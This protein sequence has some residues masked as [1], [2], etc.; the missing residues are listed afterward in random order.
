MST[1]GNRAES[2]RTAPRELYKAADKILTM[3][4]TDAF[5]AIR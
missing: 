1:T 3:S 5:A 2:L 4:E